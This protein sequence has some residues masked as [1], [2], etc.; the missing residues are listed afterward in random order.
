[1][2]S[3]QPMYQDRTWLLPLLLKV[4]QSGADIVFMLGLARPTTAWGIWRAF[5]NL[6]A[7]M[8]ILSRYLK[9]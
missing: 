3:T 4:A 7:D 2:S 9:P 8:H 1:M 6:L 5:Q